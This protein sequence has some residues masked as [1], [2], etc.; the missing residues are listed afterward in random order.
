MSKFTS[1]KQVQHLDGC[2]FLLSLNYNLERNLKLNA[3][4]YPT[5]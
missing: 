3:T 1:E 4:N 2:F 5:A